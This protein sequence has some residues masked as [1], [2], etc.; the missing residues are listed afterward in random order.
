[1]SI[2]Q[3]YIGYREI[4]EVPSD[5][6][7]GFFYWTSSK[8]VEPIFF[9]FDIQI[10]AEFFDGDS[11]YDF[12]N[13]TIEAHIKNPLCLN[14]HY[15]KEG[16]KRWNTSGMIHSNETKLKM[17][18]THKLR[19]GYKMSDLAK[20]KLSIARIGLRMSEESKAKLSESKKGF[21]HSIES[22][23]KMSLSKS[24]ENCSIETRAKLSNAK[25]G[26]NN[27]KAKDWIILNE[28]DN[29]IFKIKSLYSWCKL[30]NIHYKKL[31]NTLTTNT[32]YNGFKIL[33]K[34]K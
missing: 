32:F 10:L 15:T 3:F 29:S 8:V 13:R 12:E 11:A 22:K 7:L 14:G 1:M 34:S 6:D 16:K 24:G 28:I 25:Q 17:S 30:S 27:P 5:Q 23:I 26:E 21:I 33:E 2:Y 19:R 9:E 4:N 18:I 20:S 31:C